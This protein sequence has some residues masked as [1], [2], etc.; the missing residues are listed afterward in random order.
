M[1]LAKRHKR[2][3]MWSKRRCQL[4]EGVAESQGKYLA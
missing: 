1:A 4:R 3:I 2:D